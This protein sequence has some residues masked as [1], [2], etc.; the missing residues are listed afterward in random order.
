VLG[1]VVKGLSRACDSPL[2]IEYALEWFALFF[3]PG[4][5]TSTA[6]TYKR[7]LDLHIIPVLGD[8]NIEDATV[9][10]VQ[11]LFNAIPANLLTKFTNT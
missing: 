5:E 1:Y 2:L 8:M 7:Q 10:D 11:K 3:K 4:I 9:N 6:V